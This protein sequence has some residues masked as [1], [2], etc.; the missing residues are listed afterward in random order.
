VNHPGKQISKIY[1]GN[2]L[3]SA[4][5]KAATVANACN[6]FRACGL[7][8]ID[9]SAIPAHVFAPASTSEMSRGAAST[10]TAV[11]PSATAVDE[12]QSSVSPKSP[13][14]EAS[15]QF[16]AAVSPDSQL[17]VSFI[18]LQPSPV[19]K[20]VSRQGSR[21]IQTAAVLTSP[22]YRRSLQKQLDQTKVKKTNNKKRVAV[23]RKTIEKKK[24]AS[25]TQAKES[26]SE[27]SSSDNTDDVCDDDS[28]D[29]LPLKNLQAKVR[30]CKRAGDECRSTYDHCVLCGEYGP[31]N[32]WWF[33][34]VL[35]SAWAH[36]ACT[37]A[38]SPDGY[39][40]DFCK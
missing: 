5:G 13:Q 22:T 30:L 19:I 38:D 23:T 21:R 33:R 39:Q 27:D 15:G 4:W 40:C 16:I 37:D 24:C 6:G 2:L 14:Q 17:D 32:E 3:K 8:P 7:F 31:G 1:F 18:A 35:C 10:E 34:C 26:S 11:V 36:K 28:D 9:Q 20:R 12:S 29:D 25:F